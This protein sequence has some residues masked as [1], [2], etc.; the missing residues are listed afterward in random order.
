MVEDNREPLLPRLNAG[1]AKVVWKLGCMLHLTLGVSSHVVASPLLNL[2]WQC[3][4][5]G[6]LNGRGDERVEWQGAARAAWRAPPNKS[7]KLTANSADVIR[8]T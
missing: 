6:R 5:A 1:A 8:E 3:E 7:L 4:S 2:A